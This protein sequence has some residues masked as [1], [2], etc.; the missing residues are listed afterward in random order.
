MD[1]KYFNNLRFSDFYINILESDTNTAT[2][3]KIYVLKYLLD[4]KSKYFKDIVF[5]YSANVDHTTIILANHDYAVRR[6]KAAMC[7]ATSGEANGNISE[8][9]Y[10]FG[11]VISKSAFRNC[12]SGNS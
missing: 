6:A 10:C 4:K 12:Q 2:P 9:D 5:Q 8:Y 3:H 7:F 1:N 11:S